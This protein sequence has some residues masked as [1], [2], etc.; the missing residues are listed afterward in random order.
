MYLRK[1]AVPIVFLLIIFGYVY[2]A[3]ADA[4]PSGFLE[5]RIFTSTYDQA[6]CIHR[7]KKFFHLPDAPYSNPS[8]EDEAIANFDWA[9]DAGA[10][11]CSSIGAGG[12][13]L[14]LRYLEQC[15]DIP[16]MTPTDTP[17]TVP[18]TDTQTPTAT[19]STMTPTETNTE[20]PTSTDTPGTVP[21]TPSSTAT[22]GPTATFTPTETHTPT[23][24]PTLTVEPS[25]TSTSTPGTIPPTETETLTPT[26]G[27]IPPTETP[28]TI[29]PTSTPG[30]IPPPPDAPH[31][32]ALTPTSE[33]GILSHEYVYW[34]AQIYR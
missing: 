34:L 14:P 33:P 9:K 11:E 4:P 1:L 25:S 2:K 3:H 6:V 28:G 32:T 13:L 8:N 17:G 23:S 24:T 27:T 26:P 7:L 31:P 15:A 21:P 12:P 29:P 22:E 16:T 20:T 19:V 18:P 30:T 5:C 10:S